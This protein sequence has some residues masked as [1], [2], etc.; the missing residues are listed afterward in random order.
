MTEVYGGELSEGRLPRNFH[1][2]T[3]VVPIRQ[4]PAAHVLAESLLF[5]LANADEFGGHSAAKARRQ[6][7]SRT[8]R[9][10]RLAVK[11]ADWCRAATA[12]VRGI[13]SAEF[14]T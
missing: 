11:R 5:Q 4:A 6:R 14:L 3:A 10:E 1:R 8:R 2:P 12:R 13:Y 7:L 9:I